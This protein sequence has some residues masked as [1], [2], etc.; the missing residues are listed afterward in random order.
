[1]RLFVLNVATKVYHDSKCP[2]VSRIRKPHRKSVDL[3]EVIE[4]R[5]EACKYCRS[6]SYIFEKHKQTYEEILNSLNQSYKCTKKWLLI[7]TEMSFWKIGFDVQNEQFVLFHGNNKPSS[8]IVTE[9][10]QGEYHRQHDVEYKNTIAEYLNY[11]HDHD[12][13]EKIGKDNV[14][15]QTHGK[16]NKRGIKKRIR[17]KQKRAERLKVYKQLEIY[18]KKT[19]YER[20]G[21]KGK[22][23]EKYGGANHERRI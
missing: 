4:R 22:T 9:H 17:N 18:Q 7:Q 14:K 16:R 19:K 5:F 20:S 15:G 6:M 21:N 2:Y 3:D 12:V 23:Q 8:N 10:K 11:I 13:Y 1:M